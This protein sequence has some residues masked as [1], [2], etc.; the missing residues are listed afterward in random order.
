MV[1]CD[2][3]D[4]FMSNNR[5]CAKMRCTICIALTK[6]VVTSSVIKGGAGYCTDKVDSEEVATLFPREKINK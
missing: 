5:L 4:L 2:T 1:I 3:T 6:K